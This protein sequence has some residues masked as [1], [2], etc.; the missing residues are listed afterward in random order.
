MMSRVNR[1]RG[2]QNYRIPVFG[3][4]AI[5]LVACVPSFLQGS[6]ST[7]SP[8]LCSTVSPSE[9]TPTLPPG[10]VRGSPGE[11]MMVRPPGR[12]MRSIATTSGADATLSIDVPDVPLLVGGALGVEVVARNVGHDPIAVR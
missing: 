11:G 3:L 12:P 10:Y 6:A 1:R 7:V 2:R 4:L 9:P 8:S 5:V